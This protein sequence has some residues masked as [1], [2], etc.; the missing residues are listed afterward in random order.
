METDLFFDPLKSRIF[1]IIKILDDHGCVFAAQ[2]C[3]H[4]LHAKTSQS[5]FLLF[6]SIIVSR[7]GDQS[8]TFKEVLLIVH[9]CRHTPFAEHLRGIIK[10]T[11]I[12]DLGKLATLDL[13]HK[14]FFLQSDRPIS[15]NLHI[16]AILFASWPISKKINLFP[17]VRWCL[18]VR[19]KRRGII[20][21]CVNRI[22]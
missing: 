22:W 11:L 5:L 6:Q 1:D 14:F 16:F 13:L 19:T 12:K 18:L 21:P 7:F 9:M 2:L 8:C 17:S 4:H 10:E 20:V 15:I 3:V